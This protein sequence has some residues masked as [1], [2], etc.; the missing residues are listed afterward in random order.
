MDATALIPSLLA[1]YDSHRRHLPWRAPPGTRPDPYHVWLS[2]IMLQQTTVATVVPYYRG[3]LERWPKVT[4]LAQAELDSV[5]QAW[6][7]LGYYARARNLHACARTVAEAHDG[8]FPNTD[9]GL[10]RLPGIGAYTAAAIAAI[11]FDRPVIAVDGNVERVM[12][13]LNAVETPLPKAKPELT[14]LAQ[15]L[16]TPH[17]PGDVTQALMD[18]GATLCTPRKPKCR[19]CPWMAACSGY[20]LDSAEALPRK[21][22]RAERPTRRAVAFFATDSAG[23][24]LLR[25]R[26][27]RGLLGAMIE[28][29]SSPWLETPSMPSLADVIETAPVS[30]PWRP[31]PG[32]VRHTFT[33]F[34]LELMV[35]V[36]R[37]TQPI[38]VGSASWVAVDRLADT[39][40]PSVMRKIIRHAL[41]HTAS[42]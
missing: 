38:E 42:P 39:A 7:G 4:D 30:A 32:L 24:I 13:R 34:H 22:P 28:V 18:L 8:Q 2:E 6:A 15:N 26:P 41:A 16:A 17:R 31:L 37:C 29:P 1:W 33:H 21:A 19:L 36:A 20:R 12:A 23:A 11:A 5:L 9:A 27:A 3:F 10:R 25:R 14:S 35:A 40:L